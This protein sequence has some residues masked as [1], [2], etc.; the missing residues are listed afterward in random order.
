M[1]LEPG[2][3]G[4]IE[5]ATPLVRIQLFTDRRAVH[6]RIP[7]GM[8]TRHDNIFREKRRNKLLDELA[9]IWPDGVNHHQALDHPMTAMSFGHYDFISIASSVIKLTGLPK[10]LKR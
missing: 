5:P 2:S 4:I 1:P 9:Y 8:S 10:H 3:P 7:G 6:L